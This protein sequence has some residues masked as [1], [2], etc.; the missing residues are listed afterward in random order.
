M[1]LYFTSGVY[2][3]PALKG[4]LKEKYS[5]AN[6]LPTLFQCGFVGIMLLFTASI[7]FANNI[8][9]TLYGV[10]ALIIFLFVGYYLAK[11][12]NKITKRHFFILLSILLCLYFA[13]NFYVAYSLKYIIPPDTDIIYVSVADLM[14]D[15]RLNS[16]NANLPMYYTDMKLNTNADYF[17]MFPNNIAH[18]LTLY[19]AFLLAKPFGIQPVTPEGHVWAIF[20]S[21]L[22]MALS[23][24]F[25]CLIVYRLF[26]SNAATLFALF[27]CAI[28]PTFYYSVPNF[29]TD[30]YILLPT[31]MALYFFIIFITNG[32][33]RYFFISV[34]LFTWASLVKITAVVVLVAALIY[35]LF[36]QNKISYAKKLLLICLA[37]GLVFLLR[38]LFSLWYTNSAMFDFSRMD[39]LR[40]PVSFWFC[41]G[42]HDLGTINNPDRLYAI[43]IT[44]PALRSR[45]LWE[46][47]FTYYDQ[48]SFA[49]LVA[50]W[51]QKLVWTWNDGLYEGGIYAYNSSNANWSAAIV[52]P[53]TIQYFLIYW[54][55]Q[56]HIMMLY[57]G[58]LA[59]GVVSLIKR[60]LDSAFL[61]NL[62]IF[63]TMLY[64][65]IFETAPRRAI[66]SL[67]FFFINLIYLHQQPIIADIIRKI[68]PFQKNK[69]HKQSSQA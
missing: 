45:L 35:Y 62:C 5:R 41:F 8:Y 57:L 2:A 3:L 68:S 23:V 40:M 39:E 47:A 10:A 4:W 46:R 26:H 36:G 16:I 50:L 69:R 9:V 12:I 11:P 14:D 30:T 33:Y 25:V 49:D 43:S 67:P 51:H 38:F 19:F 63:G 61:L 42:S 44:D 56:G 52:Q 15:G 22:V 20:I 59:S 17:C 60:K 54:F 66:I 32:K 55:S 24:L 7:A 13:F 37:C 31:L 28:C 21:S 27:L 29:Y 34:T 6:V 53:H 48:Y 65:Q 18:L 58:T 64:L 1:E